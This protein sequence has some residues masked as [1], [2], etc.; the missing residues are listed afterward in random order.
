MGPSAPNYII[1]KN[2]QSPL[3]TPLITQ[4]K[5]APGGGPCPRLRA[6]N[7]KLQHQVSCLTQITRNIMSIIC[8]LVQSRE[9]KSAFAYRDILRSMADAP[10][11]VSNSTLHNDLGIPSIKDVIQERQSIPSIFNDESTGSF[12]SDTRSTRQYNII[13]L[14]V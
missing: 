8:G 5:A 3:N 13:R 4:G 14:I 11:Y 7:T 12:M 6:P 9:H 2:I 1:S 10:R